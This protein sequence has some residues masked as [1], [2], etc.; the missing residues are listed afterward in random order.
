[1]NKL[2]LFEAVLHTGGKTAEQ[3]KAEYGDA[4]D[5]ETQIYKKV[6][7]AMDGQKAL[8]AP[9]YISS[10]EYHYMGLEDEA[11]HKEVAYLMEQD[12]MMGCYIDQREEFDRDYD[13]G[14]Y[15]PDGIFCLK[16][17]QVEIIREIG[18]P[19]DLEALQ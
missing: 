19:V 2:I 18:R 7:D 10:D 11:Q 16:K 12:P 13:S 5:E 6:F 9:S 1:M 3:L 17:E 14:N 15:V 8:V 4:T